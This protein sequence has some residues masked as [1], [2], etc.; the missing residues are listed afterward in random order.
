M[1][2]NAQTHPATADARR[3]IHYETS[4]LLAEAAERGHIIAA[5]E[6]LRHEYAIAGRTVV[7]LGCGVGTNL[8]VFAA[9][10]AVLGVEGLEQ[11]AAECRKRGIEVSVADLEQ[12][13]PIPDR[14]ADLVLCLD[15]LE[16]LVNPP[17]CLA[18]AHR[19][20]RDGGYLVVNVPNHFDW[21]GRLRVL[22]GSGIDSQHYFA[23]SPH[24][25]YPH[26]RFFSRRSIE[27]LLVTSGFELVRD[28]GPRFVSF[29]KARLWEGLGLGGTLRRL[30]ARWPDMFSTGFFLL[31][32]KR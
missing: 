5:L 27:K 11:A 3:K 17:R 19:I 1:Q 9:D 32:R 4:W 23:D 12:E 13:V 21:R 30:Q 26:L 16:H 22:R 8:A 15:V 10:N 31:C 7:E 29:P 24:W 6:S 2:T 20:L 14:S 28:Y 25:E 18:S